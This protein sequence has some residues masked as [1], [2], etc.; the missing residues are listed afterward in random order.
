MHSWCIHE[1][2]I[3]LQ[4]T[5]IKNL[6][7]QSDGGSLVSLIWAIDYLINANLCTV[8]SVIVGSLAVPIFL[9]G[10]KRVAFS[11]TKFFIH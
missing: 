2:L 1:A 7:I 9:C 8:G 11:D 4:Q 3:G 6:L 5:N 10:K